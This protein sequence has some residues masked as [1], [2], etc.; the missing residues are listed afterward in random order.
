[1]KSLFFFL[2][3]FAV[4]LSALRQTNFVCPVNEE[5]VYPWP[6]PEFDCNTYIVCRE[7][8]DGEWIATTAECDPY[9]HQMSQNT[10]QFSGSNNLCPD[11]QYSVDFTCTGTGV[12]PVPDHPEMWMVC[13]GTARYLNTCPKG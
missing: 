1:M 8:D 10:C 12:F 3:I 9:K 4:S 7:D 5:S 11:G 13:F 6:D 2:F